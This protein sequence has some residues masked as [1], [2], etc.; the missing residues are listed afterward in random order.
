M[1]L[2]CSQ[3]FNL[4]LSNFQILYYLNA[5]VSASLIL[6]SC[7]ILNFFLSNCMFHF[8]VFD[9]LNSLISD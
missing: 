5:S 3:F 7:G 9:D 1:N 4:F 8:Y 6:I 2:I